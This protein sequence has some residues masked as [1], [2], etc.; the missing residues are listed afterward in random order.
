VLFP[1]SVLDESRFLKRCLHLDGKGRVLYVSRR[2]AILARFDFPENGVPN[3]K[4]TFKNN[5]PSGST[6]LATVLGAH[7]LWF[8]LLAKSKPYRTVGLLSVSTAPRSYYS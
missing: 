8:R 3:L 7:E 1:K 4:P 2:D 6:A 5:S